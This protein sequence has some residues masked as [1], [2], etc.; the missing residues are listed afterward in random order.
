MVKQQAKDE[1]KRAKYALFGCRMPSLPRYDVSIFQMAHIGIH[2]IFPDCK[3]NNVALR[4]I[5]RLYL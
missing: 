5:A 1:R 2:R 4:V 3:N